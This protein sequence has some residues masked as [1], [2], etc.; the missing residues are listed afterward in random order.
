MAEPGTRPAL[1]SAEHFTG[2]NAVGLLTLVA[3]GTGF[4]VLLLLVRIHAAGLEHL[5]HSVAASLNNVVADRTS[6]VR[7]LRAVTG[8]G[9]NSVL[10]GLVTVS[11]A[12]LL[13]RRQVHLAIYL[14]V[15]GLGALALD[16]TL[17]LLIGRLRPVVAEPIA[18][19]T[20]NSF[21]SGHALNSTVCY[22]ALLLVYL[23]IIP[24]RLRRPVISAVIALVAA[25]GFSRL[26]LGVHYLSDVVAGWLLGIAW[27]AITA[28]A[29]RRWRLEIGLPKRPLSEGLEPEAADQLRLRIIHVDHPW[30]SA[31]WLIAAFV[32]IMGALFGVGQLI[33]R[34]SPPF[35]EAVPR[36]LAAHR[37]PRLDA[38]SEFWSQAG[39]THSVLA[40]ALV[41][42][43]LAVAIT[44]R[45]RPAVFVAVAL[46]GE[47]GLFLAVQTTVDRPRP[48][49]THLDGTLPTSSFPSG[50]VAAT[51]CLYGAFA[52]LVVPR[53][54]GIWR[55]LAIA[56][57]VLMP[58]LVATSRMYR[59]EHHPMDVTAGA[60]LA[61]VWL[62]AVA[63]AVRPNADLRDRAERDVTPPTR[64]PAAVREPTGDVRTG[65]DRTRS[66]V[67]VNPTKLARPRATRTEMEAALASADWA[68]PTWLET[69][70]D[71]PGA[72]QARQAIA[73]GVEV[74]FALGGDG[75]VR[76]CAGSLADTD[77]ALAVVPFG[78]GNL[79][80]TNLRL[81]PRVPEAVAT[82]T[83]H[84][85]RHLDIGLVDGRCFT[86]MA[87]MGLD[88][89]MIHDAPERL[90]TRVGWL[91]YAAAA[92]KHLCT[93]PMRVDISLDHAPVLRRD[94]RMVLIGNVGRLQGGVS[95]L[96]DASPT[97]G[98][99]DVALLMPPRRRDWMPLAWALLRRRPT[100]PT[101]E[102]FQAKHIEITSDHEQPRELDG[103]L[104]EPSHT[105]I[106]TVQ[107]AALWMCVPREGDSRI[108][109]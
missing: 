106:A 18:V 2:R 38:I 109:G 39:N 76:A 77:V 25:I 75:T 9:A 98:M 101:M 67:V 35:D 14:V 74:V 46:V 49:V 56:V 97:D 12:G 71:D 89:E 29:F 66:A 22:G 107:P 92:A 81:P 91:A 19:G 10:W 28:Y 55:A 48:L 84:H 79:L 13:V 53:T 52:I 5:D 70:P 62:T 36:W 58:A 20:G 37:T 95:L 68:E 85:R 60:I 73:A 23:P 83:T 86:V 30:L 59:G 27:L 33:V 94:A 104:I 78:T 8:L 4:G 42:A 103:D 17:K 105:M 47:L 32:L 82:A 88:A 45:W 21:P 57:A 72:G 90:K 108:R 40:V 65:R 34:L 61:L 15:I 43:P 16:P 51:T 11:A 80:A 99:L 24:A 64:V 3:T 69:T 87:G 41:I 44:R 1:H 7:L 96:P 102:T 50:H 31:T 63:V 26:A 93:R 54:H 6:V 100:P